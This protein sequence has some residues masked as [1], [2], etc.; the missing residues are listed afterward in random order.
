MAGARIPA[1]AAGHARRDIYIER[2]RLRELIAQHKIDAIL[3][4]HDL[5]P[6]PIALALSD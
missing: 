1:D 5:E 4:K 6:Q 2:A 3:R